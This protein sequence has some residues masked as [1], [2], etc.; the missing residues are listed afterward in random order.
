MSLF[1][2]VPVLLVSLTASAASAQL[3]QGPPRDATSAPAQAGTAT[4]RGRVVAADTGRPLRRARI[5]ASPELEGQPRNTSTD[6]D[7]QYE[8]TDLPAGRYSLSVARSGYLPLTYGQRRPREAAK[9]LSLADHQEVNHIDFA[10]PRMS[11]ISGRVLDEAGD[12]IE[13]VN[14]YAARSMFRDGR[15][16]LVLTGSS[17]NH[18]DDAGQYRVLGLT[19]GSYYV[20]AM[21]HETWTESRAGVK[22]VMGYAPTYFPGTTQTSEARRVTVRVGEEISNTDF[23]LVPGR[24]ARIAGMAFDVHGRP[25]QNV[26]LQEQVRGED[27]EGFATIASA[28]V[29]A[30]GAFVITSVPPGQYVLGTSTP[31]NSP[32][33]QVAI[34]P[35]TVDGADLENISLTGSSGGTVSGHVV[36]EDGTVPN[37][38]RL[39]VSLGDW[40]TG[41][42]SPFSMGAFGPP[43]SQVGAAGAFS[44]KAATGQVRVNVDLPD[45]WVVKVVRQSGQD[46]TDAPLDLR[47]GETVSD[48]QV[49]ITDKITTVSGELADDKGAPITDATVLVFATDATKWSQNPRFIKAARPDQQGRWQ[50]KGLPAGEYLAVAVDFVEDGQWNDPEYLDSIRRYGQKLTLAAAASE[51][52]S[53]MLAVP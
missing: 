11:V 2:L 17:Q 51:T 27:F 20:V 19:P 26:R 21:T 31:R 6:S 5:T 28:S 41:Q 4:I 46:L 49:V 47:S 39:R 36:T 23:A 24:A 40:A 18:T 16:Q 32:D 50:I 48:V 25:F 14:V 1:R 9:P 37:L 42:P 10:V 22:Q 52:I 43:F 33:P 3:R 38:P 45:G 13:G 7:G 12:P 8:L 35:I 15:R 34:L 44:I 29:Q 53:L 30:D